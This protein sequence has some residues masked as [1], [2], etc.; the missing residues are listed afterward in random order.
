MT[1]T[2]AGCTTT[3]FV[4]WNEDQRRPT[5]RGAVCWATGSFS[6]LPQAQRSRGTPCPSIRTAVPLC[7]TD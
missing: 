2:G 5:T 4:G 1:I 3:T 6:G 7:S